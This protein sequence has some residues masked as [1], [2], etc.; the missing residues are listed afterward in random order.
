MTQKPSSSLDPANSRIA[1]LSR[2]TQ[3]FLNESWATAWQRHLPE[4]ARIYETSGEPAYG[5]KARRLFAP[6]RAEMTSRELQPTPRL[7]GSFRN[8]EER[9]GPTD[10]HDRRILIRQHLCAP[11]PTTAARVSN[12]SVN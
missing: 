3:S 4:I 6:L 10:D 11:A 5:V 2:H 12:H 7:P 8:S 9:W 1:A